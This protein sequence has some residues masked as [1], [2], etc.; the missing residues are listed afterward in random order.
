MAPEERRRYLYALGRMTRRPISAQRLAD[1]AKL[2]HR[3]AAVFSALRAAPRLTRI[4]EPTTGPERYAWRPDA[5]ATS[6]P[7]M[8]S[9]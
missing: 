6:T 1:R 7:R 8:A 2:T 4:R 5:R 3:R 9:A